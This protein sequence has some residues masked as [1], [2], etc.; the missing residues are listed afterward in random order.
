MSYDPFDPSSEAPRPGEPYA[1]S[2]RP[3][4]GDAPT[5]KGRV[6][7]PAIGL[8]VIGIL[9][10]FFALYMVV[11]S[12]SSTV[13][14]ADQ[15]KAQQVKMFGLMSAEM[16]AEAEKKS[17]SEIKTQAMLVNW[18]L[19]LF[20]FLASVL[21]I[22]G[23]IRMMSLKSYALGVCG[24]IAA[25]IPCMSATACCGLGEGIGIWALVVLLNPDVKS[26]FR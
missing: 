22:A 18:P 24:A 2:D 6:Q 3:L 17:A 23:G 12:V 8:I 9:N 25:A 19:T 10:L 1:Y 7:G 11:N 13:M 15:L 16:K 21:P 4:P 14:S 26:A 20:A 5:V